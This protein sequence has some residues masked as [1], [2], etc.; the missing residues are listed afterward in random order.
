MPRYNYETRKPCGHCKREV[1]AVR[2]AGEPGLHHS[3]H[4]AVNGGFCSGSL[5]EVA[6]REAA[7]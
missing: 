5:T 2:I 7:P 4:L 1:D 3:R 6:R